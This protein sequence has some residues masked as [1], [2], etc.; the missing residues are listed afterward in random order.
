MTSQLGR[1]KS[2]NFFYSVGAPREKIGKVRDSQMEKRTAKI[3]IFV[4]E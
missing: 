3:I 4:A 2:L 1:G